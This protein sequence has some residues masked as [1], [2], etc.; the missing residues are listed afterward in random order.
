M[1]NGIDQQVL[2]PFYRS[3]VPKEKKI[4]CE[5]ISKG[6]VTHLAFSSRREYEGYLHECCCKHYRECLLF[7]VLWQKYETKDQRL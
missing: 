1:A 6:S 7:R 4:R 2:C 3:T 5:G